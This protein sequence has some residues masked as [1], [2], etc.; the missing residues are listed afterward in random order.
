[1]AVDDRGFD[2]T[3][4]VALITGGANGIGAAVARR[5]AGDGARVVLADV[6]A[7]AGTALAQELDG[8]FVRCDVREPA[9]S[10][11]AVAAAVERFGGLDVAFL[12]AGVAGGGGVGDDF[13]LAAYRRAMGINFDGVFFGV[14]AALPALRARGGGDIV[15]TASMAALTATPFDPVYGA[16]KAAVVGLVR[17]LGPKLAEE[18]VRVNALC[19]SFADTDILTPMKGHLQE[20]G[21]PI[22]DVAD[23]VE[24][25][26]RILAAD[27]AGEAWYVVPGRPA[28]P[29]K[30]RGVPGPR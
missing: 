21:F 2:G 19:P 23:V 14:H 26:M 1:M 18:G 27:G 4:K 17:A 8:V 16:N 10:E 3:G 5:L 22:L 28:E 30:F 20:T 11:A 12:N 9:E 24:A 15:V 6:D 25:F 7:A 29:F 13:D